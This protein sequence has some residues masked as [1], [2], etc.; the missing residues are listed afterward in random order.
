MRVP[1]RKLLAAMRRTERVVDVE[2]LHPARLHGR[3]EL[4]E[5]RRRKPLRFRPA[6]RI[7]QARDGRLRR[8]R[9]PVS[10]QRPTATFIKGEFLAA[11]GWQ[12]EGKQRIVGHG[13][14][15]AGLIARSSSIGHR[16]VT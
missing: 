10:G 4:I 5:E 3:T 6:R 13:G 11:D 14:C 15:G 2:Y 16:F 12:V 9:R 7:L 8:Q 1:E